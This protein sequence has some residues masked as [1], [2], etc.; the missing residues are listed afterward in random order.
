VEITFKN[1]G[2]AI[3]K[4]TLERLFTPLVTTKPGGTGLGLAICRRII[5]AHGGE[6]SVESAVGKG[7]ILKVTIPVEPKPDGGD[8][9]EGPC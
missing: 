4:E 9:P 8:K 3:P 5:E 7:T 6:I 1:T 2:T